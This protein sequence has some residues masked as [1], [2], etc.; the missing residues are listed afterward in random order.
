MMNLTNGST[1]STYLIS[2]LITKS[3]VLEF[4]KAVKH[5]IHIYNKRLSLLP[6]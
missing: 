1:L 5:M 3:V 6:N 2:Y 4:R